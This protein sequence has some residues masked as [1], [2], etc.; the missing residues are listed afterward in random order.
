MAEQKEA[1]LTKALKKLQRAGATMQ[2]FQDEK[3]CLVCGAECN[4]RPMK[5]KA[6]CVAKYMEGKRA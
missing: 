4:Y 5:H 2:I 6:D 1:R 3:L